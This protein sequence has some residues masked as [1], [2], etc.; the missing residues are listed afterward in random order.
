MANLPSLTQPIK[1]KTP[2]IFEY[3]FLD[4]PP[5]NSPPSL[6]E[7]SFISSLQCNSPDRVFF[8]HTAEFTSTA[9]RQLACVAPTRRREEEQ[10][11]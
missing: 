6:V 11:E 10:P 7:P 1:R 5:I 3:A 8:Y 9:P 4:P 2:A